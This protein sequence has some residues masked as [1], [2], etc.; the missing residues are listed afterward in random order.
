MSI[1]E[2]RGEVNHKWCILVV[3]TD[4]LLAVLILKQL[5]S[6]IPA[7]WYCE[8]A[9]SSQ[10]ETYSICNSIIVMILPF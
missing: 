10:V 2:I 6:L 3:S 7:A 8:V 9:A 4:A 5:S 1:V